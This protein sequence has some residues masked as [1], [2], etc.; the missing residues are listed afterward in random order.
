M[1]S[2]RD[3][4]ILEILDEDRNINRQVFDR[5]KEQVKVFQE[6]ALPKKTRDLEAEISVD[7]LI[8]NINRIV[9]NKLTSLE[10][11]LSKIVSTK[12]IGD[13][14]GRRS[15][16]NVVSNGDIITNYN[17]LIRVY[18][19]QGLSRN[20]QELIKVKLQDIKPNVDA[21]LY[22]IEELIQYLFEAGKSDKEIFQLIRSQAVFQII[23]NQLFR[24]NIYKPIEQGDIQVAIKEVLSDLSDI[25]RAEL[26]DISGRDITEKSLLKLPIEIGD[27]E[28]R[29]QQLE[30]EL[31]FNLPRGA[32]SEY[33]PKE[34]E[35]AFSMFGDLGKEMIVKNRQ[36]VDEAVRQLSEQRD[37][38]QNN[39]KRVSAQFRVEKRDLAQVIAQRDELLRGQPNYRQDDDLKDADFEAEVPLSEDIA[40]R[41]SHIKELQSLIRDLQQNILDTTEQLRTIKQDFEV[42]LKEGLDKGIARE[43]GK[44]ELPLKKKGV[45][46]L[47]PEEDAE[48]NL[49]SGAID[50]ER[51]AKMS[52]SELRTVAFNLNY[53]PRAKTSKEAIIKSIIAKLAERRMKGKGHIYNDTERHMKDYG[54]GRSEGFDDRRDDI[55]Y[56]QRQLKRD[57]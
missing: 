8:E 24:A 16:N 26:K 25:Q 27:D 9:E 1:Q 30:A 49:E 31:G 44:V 51:L 40:D 43:L 23:H 39:L 52:D 45:R 28:S 33:A 4:Q 15:Y 10:Y 56:L 48:L 17:Q 13:A 55:Y 53:T 5:E 57:Y 36:S 21:I 50:V 47:V 20:S 46:S 54:C 41:E 7:K 38:L 18:T 19:V 12:D 29:I 14:E 42:G 34:K 11:L 6:N 2:L 22:G 3:R 37:I 32:T 35:Q